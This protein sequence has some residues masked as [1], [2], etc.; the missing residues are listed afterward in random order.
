MCESVFICMSNEASKVCEL[1]YVG[2]CVRGSVDSIYSS[3]EAC[4]VCI[5]VC[6][7]MCV[8]VCVCKHVF[9]VLLKLFNRKLF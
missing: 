3:N 2:V 8:C 5:Y 9:L 7:C 6:V 1:V 4:K